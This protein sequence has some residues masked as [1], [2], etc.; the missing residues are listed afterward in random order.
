M[1]RSLKV[2]GHSYYT[3]HEVHIEMQYT[4]NGHTLKIVVIKLHLKND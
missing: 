4:E 1:F 3:D 2:C